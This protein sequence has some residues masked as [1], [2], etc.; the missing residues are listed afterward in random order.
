MSTSISRLQHVQNSPLNGNS[1]LPGTRLSFGNLHS[2]SETGV[3]R[4]SGKTILKQSRHPRG[5]LS[6]E[7]GMASLQSPR[8]TCR[9]RGRAAWCSTTS[10][11]SLVVAPTAGA[12]GPGPSP[13]IT[14]RQGQTAPG[15]EQR[16]TRVHASRAPA[17][18]KAHGRLRPT[19]KLPRVRSGPPGRWGVSEISGTSK[20][21]ASL[22]V[23]KADI[24]GKMSST[25]QR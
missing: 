20:P 8:S 24:G 12:L 7:E 18:S 14:E 25:S 6:C 3:R 16:P 21:K 5:K 9:S 22:E 19:A 17:W 1:S 10:S 23:G 13:S 15:A 2:L 4:K 11:S